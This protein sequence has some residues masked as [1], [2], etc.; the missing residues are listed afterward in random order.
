MNE[1]RKRPKG[2]RKHL[3][4]M[5]P[6]VRKATTPPD[7]WDSMQ[8]VLHIETGFPEGFDPQ[9]RAAVYA[10]FRLRQEF[11]QGSDPRPWREILNQDFIPQ[12]TDK[13]IDGASRALQV[14][15]RVLDPKKH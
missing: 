15:S 8:K 12:Y 10:F 6:E 4:E 11:S 7:A 13:V 2:L 1:R 14:I 9:A 3:R 5:K